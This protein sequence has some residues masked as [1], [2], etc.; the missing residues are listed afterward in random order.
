[1][2]AVLCVGGPSAGKVVEFDNQLYVVLQ[3][4][5]PLPVVPYGPN[6]GMMAESLLY[7]TVYTPHYWRTEGL[8]ETIILAPDGWTDAQVM[9]ELLAGY[10]RA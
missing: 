7:R 8:F 3:K 9:T 4:N 10:R 2:T 1:M 6:Y 5:E